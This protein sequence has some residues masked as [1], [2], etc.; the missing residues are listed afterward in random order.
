MSVLGGV[1]AVA[2]AAPLVAA[3]PSA[4]GQGHG[5]PGQLALAKV[6]ASEA[7]VQTETDDCAAIAQVLIRRARGKPLGVMARAYSTRVFERNRRDARRW[8]AHLHPAGLRPEG[9]PETLPWEKWQKRWL[10]LYQH[11]GRILRGEVDNPC[12][13]PPDHWGGDMDD[14][15]AEKAGWRKVNCGD[16]HN[17]FWSVRQRKDAVMASAP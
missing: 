3:T 17:N 12:Q 8:I 2:L 11:A 16:T 14:W 1:A 9:W 10:A 4:E 6:C 15:R 7:S 5:L 13:R